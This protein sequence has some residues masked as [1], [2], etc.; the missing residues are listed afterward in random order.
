M[1]GSENYR[2]ETLTKLYLRSKERC[3]E[4]FAVLV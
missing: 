3:L 1:G 4:G 2:I